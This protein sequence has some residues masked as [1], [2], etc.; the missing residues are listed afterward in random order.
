MDPLSLLNKATS[1]VS[2]VSGLLGGSLTQ[3]Q[4]LLRVHTPLGEDVLFAEDLEVW[5]GIGPA[6][7][8]A[9]GDAEFDG[10]AKQKR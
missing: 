9:L 5:E 6:N 10:A 2:T 7:G 8:P 3:G 4:R 1:L